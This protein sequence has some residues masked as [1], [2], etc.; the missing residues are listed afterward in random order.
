M[1]II[2]SIN[3]IKAEHLDAFVRNVSLHARKSNN[4]PGC[5]RYEVLADT[6]DP[7]TICLH[8]V[9]V[10]E[11]AFHAHMAAPHYVEWMQ[12][13]KDW[14]HSEQRIRRVL[15]FLHTPLTP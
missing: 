3:K 12:M 5:V 9:F 11:D 10:D 4:E 13:S 6:S 8:E 7:R 1:Y 2:F 15:R 14:R